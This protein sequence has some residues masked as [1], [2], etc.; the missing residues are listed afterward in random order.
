MSHRSIKRLDGQPSNLQDIK[1]QG[2]VAA[3]ILHEPMALND[4]VM[5]SPLKNKQV[6]LYTQRLEYLFALGSLTAGLMTIFLEKDWF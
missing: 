1:S 6:N 3:G 2:G 5:L 4:S